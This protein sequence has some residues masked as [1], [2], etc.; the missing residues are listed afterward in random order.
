MNETP[1][2]ITEFVTVLSFALAIV[3]ASMFFILNLSGLPRVMTLMVMIM[4]SITSWS[5][6]RKRFHRT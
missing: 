1:N 6:L 4:I 2:K 5:Y 3:A